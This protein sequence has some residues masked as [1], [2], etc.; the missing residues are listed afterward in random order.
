[1]R[2]I[3]GTV[4][5]A[6]TA[7]LG[8]AVVPASA[9]EVLPTPARNAS[10]GYD[11]GPWGPVVWTIGDS[12]SAPNPWYKPSQ[13][14]YQQ[15][16]IAWMNGAKGW[17]THVEATGGAT[18]IE[19]WRNSGGWDTFRRAAS[20]NASAIVVELGTN[21]IS[22]IYSGDPQA[23]QKIAAVF[24]YLTFSAAYLNGTGKC[25]V[26]VGM[27]ERGNASIYG[28]YDQANVAVAF[29]N[30]IKELTGTY[31]NVRYADYNALINSNATFRAGLYKSGDK[32]TIHP[33]TDASMTELAGWY[34]TQ[35]RS[36]CGI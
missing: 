32:D 22:G 34:T 33:K 24:D 16:L 30:K 31:R 9:T 26:W 20:S 27:N 11:N 29:N 28:T 18:M 15:D 23:L 21:D 19:H 1:M 4:L 25:V 8:T 6:V 5:L 2:R 3:I 7:L 17:H 13:P 36:K 12:I 35:V 14:R 10:A